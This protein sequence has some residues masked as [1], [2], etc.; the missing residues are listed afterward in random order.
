M[1]VTL[2]HTIQDPTVPRPP[3]EQALGAAGVGGVCSQHRGGPI[4][5][6]T[7]PRRRSHNPGF[8]SPHPS[9]RALAFA[10]GAGGREDQSS[11]GL[12]FFHPLSSLFAPLHPSALEPLQLLPG[13]GRL[14]WWKVCVGVLYSFGGVCVQND[15]AGLVIQRLGV[16]ERGD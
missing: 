12:F 4:L 3:S 10:A 15:G 2:R 8:G 16:K 6:P 11:P 1:I 5:L 14:A 7:C 9:S 13:A